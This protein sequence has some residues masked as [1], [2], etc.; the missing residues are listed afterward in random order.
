FTAAAPLATGLATGL[1]GYQGMV[2][3]VCS[4][5]ADC[6]DGD[7]CNGDERCEDNACLPA[8]Q[9]LSCD[10]DDVCTADA[11][12]AATGCSNADIVGC[13]VGDA[14]CAIDEICDTGANTCVPLGGA[15]EG[16]G[17]SGAD[18]GGSAGGLTGS[19]GDETGGDGLDAGARGDGD[20]SGCTCRSES[21]GGAGWGLVLL[22]A[23]LG[24]RR[25]TSTR[26]VQ[27]R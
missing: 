26:V 23:G 4:T 16:G 6:G 13:C 22:V 17:E 12:D 3:H 10:D 14:D 7:A 8:A 5:D 11:C 27:R 1:L 20:V 15:S 24:W 25:R 2:H 21:G 9:P 18:T 19:S